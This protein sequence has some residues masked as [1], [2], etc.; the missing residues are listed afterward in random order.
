MYVELFIKEFVSFIILF[1]CVV[2]VFDGLDIGGVVIGGVCEYF[3]VIFFEVLFINFE[4]FKDKELF[5]FNEM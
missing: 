5:G 4:L 2:L 3:M 1:V